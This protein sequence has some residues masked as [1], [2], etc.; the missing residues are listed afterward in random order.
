VESWNIY[1]WSIC[2]ALNGSDCIALHI[3]LNDITRVANIVA[4]SL[5]VS[6]QQTPAQIQFLYKHCD[7]NYQKHWNLWTLFICFYDC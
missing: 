7:S 6:T 1:S 3:H 2:D 4:M 5:C